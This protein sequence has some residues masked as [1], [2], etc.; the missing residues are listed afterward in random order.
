[1]FW[2]TVDK[3]IEIVICKNYNIINNKTKAKIVFI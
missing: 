1:M 3:P 2:Q